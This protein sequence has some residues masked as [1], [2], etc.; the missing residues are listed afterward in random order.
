MFDGFIH[1]ETLVIIDYYFLFYNMI[2]VPEIFRGGGDRTGEG[3]GEMIYQK[4]HFFLNIA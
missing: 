4:K 1:L 2:K 3:E